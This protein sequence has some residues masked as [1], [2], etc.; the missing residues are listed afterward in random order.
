MHTGTRIHIVHSSIIHQ[1]I[2]QS[3]ALPATHPFISQSLFYT[4]INPVTIR[5]MH[6]LYTRT[7]VKIYSVPCPLCS[8]MHAG[9]NPFENIIRFFPN[10]K[11]LLDGV[12]A[13]GGRILVHGNAGAMTALGPL[14]APFRDCE[15]LQEYGIILT[16]TK[17]HAFSCAGLFSTGKPM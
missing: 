7:Y 14:N 8:D 12:L 1:S 11:Q 10:V 4:F 15:R 9:D 2:R 3:F 6:A 13:R 17:V 16:V 5:P